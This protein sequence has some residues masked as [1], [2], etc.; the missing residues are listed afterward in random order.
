[1]AIWYETDEGF[2]IN[3]EQVKLIGNASK[4][5]FVWDSLEEGGQSYPIDGFESAR[6]AEKAYEILSDK[7]KDNQYV[8]SYDELL[9][10][11]DDLD[12]DDEEDNEE[13]DDEE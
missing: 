4:S 8:I 12:L 11:L 9:N 5:I 1:M 7:I 2:L 10:E 6:H 3:L 13:S